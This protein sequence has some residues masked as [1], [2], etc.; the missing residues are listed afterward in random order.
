MTKRTTTV[1][2]R[3]T[4]RAARPDLDI[5]PSASGFCPL[6]TRTMRH[7]MTSIDVLGEE[8]LVEAIDVF[9]H[10]N[11]VIFQEIEPHDPARPGERMRHSTMFKAGLYVVRDTVGVEP[12]GS[13]HPVRTRFGSAM[14]AESFLDAEREALGREEWG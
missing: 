8:V 1:R 4:V 6:W 2:E 3:L 12:D 5:V 10:D 13:K 11:I 14:H 7:V 9:P